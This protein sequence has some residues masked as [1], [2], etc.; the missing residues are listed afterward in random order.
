MNVDNDPTG[1]KAR[2]KGKSLPP[3]GQLGNSRVKAK[4]TNADRKV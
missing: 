2:I 4:A 1:G 3:S